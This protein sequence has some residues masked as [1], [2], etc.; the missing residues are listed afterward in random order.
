MDEKIF[1]ERLYA[2]EYMPCSLHKYRE[3]DRNR[4]LVVSCGEAGITLQLQYFL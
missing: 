1:T 3:H 4:G 2:Y